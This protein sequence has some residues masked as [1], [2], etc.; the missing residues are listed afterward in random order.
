MY[1]DDTSLDTAHGHCPDSTDLVDVLEGQAQ[2][3]VAGPLGGLD[4]VQSLQQDGSLVPVHVCGALN[5]VVTLEAGDG[6][7][8]DLQR[9]HS[10]SVINVVL[11]LLLSRPV[12]QDDPQ[13]HSKGVSAPVCGK[14]SCYAPSPHSAARL[15]LANPVSESRL[16]YSALCTEHKLILQGPKEEAPRC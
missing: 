4:Q 16:R 8:V 11:E 1:L 14:T 9:G 6:H 3:L 5:H 12:H 15:R 13:A 10:G 7:K 2:G